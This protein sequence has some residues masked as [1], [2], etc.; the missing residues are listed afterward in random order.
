MLLA[1]SDEETEVLGDCIL[2]S[3]TGDRKSQDMNT[4]SYDSITPLNNTPHYL[5]QQGE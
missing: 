2:Q 4:V 1:V 5:L 3:V